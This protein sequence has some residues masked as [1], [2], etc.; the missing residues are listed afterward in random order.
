[1]DPLKFMLTKKSVALL[2]HINPD[3]DAYGSCLALRS[4]LRD[5]KIDC[6]IIVSEP[7]SF[8]LNFLDTDVIIYDENASYDYECVCAVDVSTKD[9]LGSR[10]A[11]FDK[12]VSTAW[13]DHHISDEV[14]SPVSLV[15]PNAGA[16]AEIVYDLFVANSI[17]ITKKRADYLYCALSA[18][19]GS[20]RFSNTSPHSAQTLAAVLEAGCDVAE[21]A[22]KLYYRDT[23]PQMKL[24]AATVNTLELFSDERI[25]VCHVTQE[26]I[27]S[28]N[29][30]PSD[31]GMLS[32]IPRSLCTVEVSAV[33]R[34]EPGEDKKVKVSFRSKGSANVEKIAAVFGGGGHEKA[35]GATIPGTIEEVKAKILPLLEKAVSET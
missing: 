31:A 4:A 21:M 1:M 18:D 17:Q 34:E 11:L 20:F 16:T 10:D 25:G 6:D 8:H 13:I 28:C 30:L 32:A 29:A 2:P 12:A 5:N 9:R 26:M 27:S 14:F 3:W 35:A 7:L 33:L 19:T 23:L 15:V 22:N 24:R